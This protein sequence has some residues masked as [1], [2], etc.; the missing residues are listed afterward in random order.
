MYVS[1]RNIRNFNP[2]FK[3]KKMDFWIEENRA[4]RMLNKNFT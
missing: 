2:L 4:V 3:I 1:V